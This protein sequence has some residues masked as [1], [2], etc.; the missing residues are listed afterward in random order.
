MK[1]YFLTFILATISIACFTQSYMILPKEGKSIRPEKIE[2]KTS[3]ILIYTSENSSR[4]E[5][6]VNAIRTVFKNGNEITVQ[7]FIKELEAEKEKQ[8]SEIVKSETPKQESEQ[9][10][11]EKN[12]PVEKPKPSEPLV[13]NQESP[14][15]ISDKPDKSKISFSCPTLKSLLLRFYDRNDDGEIS[16]DEAIN[17]VNLN[18]SKQK[19]SSLD[20]IEHFP[21]LEILICS[22]NKLNKIDVSKNKSLKRLVCDGNTIS[23]LDISNNSELTSLD[24]SKNNLNDLNISNNTKLTILNCAENKLTSLN[25]GN[26]TQLKE[27]NCANNKISSI[28]FSNCKYLNKLNC[29]NN[30]IFRLILTNNNLLEELNCAYNKLSSLSVEGNKLLKNL[31]CYK[32]QLSYLSIKNGN[33]F[34]FLDCSKNAKSLRVMMIYSQQIYKLK[35]DKKA[36]FVRE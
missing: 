15:P 28:D 22:K 6:S 24:C 2:L 25:F 4:N 3:E 1:K 9:K 27:L 20:G 5:I 17:I 14:K 8:K 12:S 11:V 32:N 29:S 34:D 16:H 33:D 23:S 10:V 30:E 36:V 31:N 21:N 18:L 7:E 35:K 19:I 26:D 13:T